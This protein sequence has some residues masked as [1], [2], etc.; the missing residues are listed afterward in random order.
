MGDG[1]MDLEERLSQLVP[2]GISE[3]G[4][5]RMEGA[6]D[7]LASEVEIASPTGSHWR[8]TG[9]CGVAACA[10]CALGLGLGASLLALATGGLLKS[11]R[12]FC[13]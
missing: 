8:R 1:M 2:R 6:I 11:R 12:V 4:Q 9:A 10:L 5:S 3:E 13:G 7:K